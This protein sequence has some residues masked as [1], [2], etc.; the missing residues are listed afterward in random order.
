MRG[1]IAD[2]LASMLSEWIINDAKDNK[3]NG[4]DLGSVEVLKGH[5]EVNDK[6]HCLPL[7]S[8]KAF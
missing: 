7:L 2:M 6:N 8:I 1:Y 5:T 3:K 4:E